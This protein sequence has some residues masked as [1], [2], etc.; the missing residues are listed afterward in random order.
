MRTVREGYRLEFDSTPPTSFLP[1]NRSARE[2]P[3]FVRSELKRLEELGCI[4]KVA[5]RPRVVN[6][7]SVVMSG[8]LRL[9]L[10]G[11]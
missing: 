8:K 3:D 6:P 4:E 7:M 1:N 5:E 11:S 2:A 10:D 9:V